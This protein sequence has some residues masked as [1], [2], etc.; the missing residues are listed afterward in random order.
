MPADISYPD[1]FVDLLEIQWGVGFLSPGGREEVLEILRDVDLSGKR[2][3]DIGCGVGGPDIVIAENLH[4]EKI[5]GIDIEPQL[6]DRAT[7]NVAKSGLSGQIDLL[8]VDPGPLPF[9]DASFDVVFSKD[10]LIHIV[11]KDA[12]YREILRVLKPG[13]LF[14]AS[15]WLAGEAADAMP[16]YKIWRSLSP[17]SF[18]MQTAA[19]SLSVLGQAGFVDISLRDRNQWYV[20]AAMQEV[21]MMETQW[22]DQYLAFRTEEEYHAG[23]ALRLANAR[24]AE[25]GGLRPTHLFGSRKNN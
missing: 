20:Q 1:N 18:T 17:H 24:A 14:A 3:L 15:D 10:S 12:F 11:D 7:S 4:P 2:V 8:L 9:P 5:V 6:I 19:E 13:G 22:R 25:C 23:I 21:R 16:D